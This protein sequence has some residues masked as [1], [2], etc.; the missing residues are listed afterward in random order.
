MRITDLFCSVEERLCRYWTLRNG[1]SAEGWTQLI[2]SGA[3]GSHPKKERSEGQ[4]SS[5]T[6]RTP[7]ERSNISI[8]KC[9]MSECGKNL[10]VYLCSGLGWGDTCLLWFTGTLTSLCQMFTFSEVGLVLIKIPVQLEILHESL[11]LNT[12]YVLE[13]D[14]GQFQ[15]KKKSFKSDLE[16]SWTCIEPPRILVQTR[17]TVV[18]VERLCFYF[19]ACVSW[20]VCEG[21]IA[22]LNYSKIWESS[23]SF[24]GARR[25]KVLAPSESVRW[26]ELVFCHAAACHW[27][28]KDFWST[29]TH[30]GNCVRKSW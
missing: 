15:K 17:R 14:Q 3:D 27:I 4:H 11:L 7:Q 20:W 5:K 23:E 9:W 2:F 22:G 19:R 30:S 8:Y 12:S 18:K 13:E 25:P 10:T 24:S 28:H 21:V 1:K 6:I 16:G 29:L 26:L